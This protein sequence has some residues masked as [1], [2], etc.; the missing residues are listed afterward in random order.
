LHVAGGVLWRKV[1]RTE[2][3]PVVFDFW[4]FRHHKANAVEYFDD[5]ATDQRKRMM[6]A[7]FGIASGSAEVFGN[8]CGLCLG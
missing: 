8:A 1:E 2:I 3:M 5:F 7:N 6:R 4:A